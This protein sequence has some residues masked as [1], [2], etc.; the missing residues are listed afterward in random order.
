M[1]RPSPSSA[2]LTATVLA[3]LLLA[4][5]AHAAPTGPSD[6]WAS[7]SSWLGQLWALLDA[8][9][10]EGCSIDPDGA[11]FSGEGFSVDP[12]GAG[13]SVD[14]DGAGFSV[15]PNGQEGPGALDYEGCG[16]DPHGG[17]FCAGEGP[18]IDPFG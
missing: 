17:W 18:V 7:L 12:N 2:I 6:A 16:I 1:P 3:L 15:D 5:V 4:P 9:T 10:D 14:P 11:C 8:T 13:F